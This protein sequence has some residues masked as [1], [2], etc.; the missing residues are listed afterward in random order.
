MVIIIIVSALIVGVASTLLVGRLW[1]RH[2]F[3]QQ[4]TA[5]FD[6]SDPV[7]SLTYT[8]VRLAGLPQPVQRYFEI[9]LKPDQPYISYVRIKHKGRFKAGFEKDWMPIRGEQYATT[10]SPGFIWLGTTLM[11]TARDQYIAHKGRLVVSL[12]SL[13]SIVDAEG[14]AYDQAELIRWLAES[15]LYLTNLLPSDRLRWSPIDRL[16]AKLIFV[17]HGMTLEMMVFFDE[18]AQIIRIEADRAMEINRIERWVISM[19]DYEVHQDLLV[20]TVFDV[21][22]RL[23]AGDFSYAQFHITEIEYDKPTMF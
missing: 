11:F 7:G 22:W 1:L 12:L 9:A 2:Q 23:P 18:N 3:E 4:V 6:S 10:K 13:V 16:T 8:P 5:L 20:P 21:L 14:P 17:H 19:G 15:V